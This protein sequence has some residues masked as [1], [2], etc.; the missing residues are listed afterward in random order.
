M[1][2]NGLLL[3]REIRPPNCPAARL[4][5]FTHNGTF[6]NDGFRDFPSLYLRLSDVLLGHVPKEESL[7]DE[8]SSAI[9][10]VALK[11]CKTKFHGVKEL[12]QS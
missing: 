10:L 2:N 4:L 6:L 11:D 1:R 7:E 8:I 9:V 12:E 3:S 5:Q